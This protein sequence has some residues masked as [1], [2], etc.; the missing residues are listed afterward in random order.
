MKNGLA[1]E[2]IAGGIGGLAMNQHRH[3]D[4]FHPLQHRPDR[5]E[6]A[7]AMV[8]MVVDAGRVKLGGDPTASAWPVF[9]LVRGRSG[10]SGYRSSA[11][12]NR[13]PPGGP[14]ECGRDSPWRQPPSYRRHRS[15]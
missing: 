11:A 3:A 15:A 1:V 4:A 8:G 7:H 10:R 12:E 6:I 13:L 9:D 14:P 2:D 5:L